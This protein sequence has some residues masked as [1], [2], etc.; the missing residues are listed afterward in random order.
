MA[1]HIKGYCAEPRELVEL[2]TNCKRATCDGTPCARYIE[3][4]RA[5]T[6]RGNFKRKCMPDGTKFKKL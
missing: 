4:A 3:I 2:C 1:A 6:I 5:Q